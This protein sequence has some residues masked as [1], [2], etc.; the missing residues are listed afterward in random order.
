MHNLKSAVLENQIAARGTQ[1]APTVQKG[2]S[3]AIVAA[4]FV[5]L[6][7][8][9]MLFITI[10][11]SRVLIDIEI[12]AS[13]YDSEVCGVAAGQ[14]GLDIEDG[15]WCNTTLRDTTGCV[16]QFNTMNANNYR[17][18]TFNYVVLFFFVI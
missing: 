12:P 4:K 13:C 11:A 2:V 1:N 18:T 8:F 7:H 15:K 10:L 6:E 14:C 5:P 9:K 17:I 3:F 16:Q